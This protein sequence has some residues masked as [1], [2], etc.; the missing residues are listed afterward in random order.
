M[1]ACGTKLS[2]AERVA[3]QRSNELTKKAR[4]AHEVEE[5]KVKLLLLGG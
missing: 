4:R 1:G 5:Q 2:E 3:A